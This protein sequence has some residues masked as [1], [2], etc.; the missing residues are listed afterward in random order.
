[1]CGRFVQSLPPQAYAEALALEIT[2]PPEVAAAPCYNVAPTLR[3]LALRE[4]P[5][6]FAWSRLRWG[7]VPHWSDG[8]DRRF[9]MINARAETLQQRAAFRE[10]FRDRRCIVPADGFFEWR[11]ECRGRQPYLV[12]RRDGVPLFLAGLWEHWHRG[13]QVIDSCTV[14][15]TDA[16]AVIAPIHDRMPVILSHE[17]ARRWLNPKTPVDEL[18]AL[19][20]PAPDAWFEVF[21]VSTRVNSPR[22]DGPDLVQPAAPACDQS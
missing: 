2:T 8:P 9:N 13:E 12:R 15:V 5:E 6:G 4:A 21:P 1:M 10:P 11:V 18:R 20:A 16:N 3:V 17:Q 7:L 14:V 22:N 19:L